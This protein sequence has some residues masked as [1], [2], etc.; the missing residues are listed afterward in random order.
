M[1]SIHRDTVSVIALE[2]R[3]RIRNLAVDGAAAS[4]RDRIVDWDGEM[5]AGSKA[6]VAYVA[7]RDRADASSSRTEAA[8]GA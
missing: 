5:E 2:F 3:D 8:C 7:L 4:L 6:A 1:A